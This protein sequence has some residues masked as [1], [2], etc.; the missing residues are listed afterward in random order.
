MREVVNQGTARKLSSLPYEIMGKTGTSQNNRD[1]WFIGC[2]K[3]HVIG[4]WLGRD[5]DKSMK[6]IF[7]ST[8]PLEVFKRIVTA[9]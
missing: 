4:V 2:A 6:N 3:E 8:V 7:G 9:L 5:D 1:A